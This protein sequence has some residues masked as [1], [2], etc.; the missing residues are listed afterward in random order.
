MGDR[1]RRSSKQYELQLVGRT[2]DEC[3]N[4]SFFPFIL[5]SAFPMRSGAR[6]SND[7]RK[8]SS[9]AIRQTQ[10][11]NQLAI[12]IQPVHTHKLAAGIEMKLLAQLACRIAELFLLLPFSLSLLPQF[13]LLLL[14]SFLASSKAISFEQHRKRKRRRRRRKRKGKKREMRVKIYYTTATTAADII[15]LIVNTT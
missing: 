12:L 1:R 2:E 14:A 3:G 5:L 7:R 15:I 8:E 4:Y 10:A 13:P 11:S 6:K 9:K